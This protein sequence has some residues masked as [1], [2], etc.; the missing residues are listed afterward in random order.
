MLTNTLLPWIE[1]YIQSSSLQ[2]LLLKFGLTGTAIWIITRYFVY[3]LYFHPINSIPGPRVDWIPLIG[4]M[5]EIIK[6]PPGVPHQKWTQRYGSIVAYHGP[7][8]RPRLLVTD[9]TLLKQIL[10]T[11][12]YDFIKSPQTS[13]FL[14]PVVGQGVLLAE[15]DVHRYQRKMLN[16]AF[17]VQALRGLLPAIA[18][19]AIHLRDKWMKQVSKEG[20]PA[21]I[22]VSADLSLA[23]LDVIGS[24]GFGEEF[25]S[26][27]D[28]SLDTNG[29]RLARAYV[30]IFEGG[31]TLQR[32]LSLFVP[33]LRDLPTERVRALNRD[34]KTLNSEAA[35]IVERGRDRFSET[36]MSRNLLAL[37]LRQ[38]DED[39]G[40][41]MTSEDLKAQCLTFLAA[42]HETT[43]VSLSW[44]LWLLAKNPA[45]QDALRQEVKEAFVSD[46]DLP[47]Y[48]AINNLRLL[49]NVCKETMR[50]YPPVPTTSRIGVRDNVLGNHFIPKGTAVF[51][52]IMAIHTDPKYWGPDAEIFRPSR[53]DESP[54]NQAGPYTYMPFLA[55]GRQCIGYRFALIEFKII[56]ALLVSRLKFTEKPG[57]IPKPRQVVTLRPTPNMTLMVEK[58]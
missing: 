48:E 3:R 41:G 46:D 5:R 14:E 32:F 55:G 30:D 11:N 56:M 38:I 21:E 45:I 52:S 37:M 57:F 58:V 13:Q 19:P 47:S 4:N 33:L 43:A 7:W 12:Q 1:P 8:N 26:V 51:I 18:I 44:G 29:G 53:W 10:T 23:T 28:A 20:G 17:S 27:N 54:A 22:V 9:P 6:A 34:I 24:A 35:A 39:T 40:R 15:G 42:G 36:E 25:R 16:P 49:N 2:Q 50:L 31:V